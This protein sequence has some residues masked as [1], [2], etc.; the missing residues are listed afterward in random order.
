L[1]S[2]ASHRP[3]VIQ[4][5]LKHLGLDQSDWASPSIHL[6]AHRHQCWLT[7]QWHYFEFKSIDTPVTVAFGRGLDSMPESP[8]FS[9]INARLNQPKWRVGNP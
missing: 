6:S 2:E 4:K 1:K 5:I 8:H 3:D 9:P 7:I